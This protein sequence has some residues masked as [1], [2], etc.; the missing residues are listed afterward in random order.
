V[1]VLEAGFKYS[2]WCLG[3]MSSTIIKVVEVRAMEF[4][5]ALRWKMRNVVVVV[6]GVFVMKTRILDNDR[7]VEMCTEPG[8]LRHCL[9]K[10]PIT[11]VV[12]V[13]IAK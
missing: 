6:E 9:T 13:F 5:G 1:A 8:F 11:I 12:M 2:E 10:T 4:V 3:R 7:Y